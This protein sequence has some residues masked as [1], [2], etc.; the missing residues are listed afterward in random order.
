VFKSPA[1][2]R[3]SSYASINLSISSC[4]NSAIKISS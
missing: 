3:S 2:R 4:V 1:L